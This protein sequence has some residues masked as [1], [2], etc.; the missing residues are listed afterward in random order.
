MRGP[1]ERGARVVAARLIFRGALVAACLL[2]GGGCALA[3]AS[4][5]ARPEFAAGTVSPRAARNA[6]IFDRV[7]RLVAERHHDPS[8]GGL[9]WTSAG[10][11]HG[12]AAVTASDDE[13]LYRELNGMLEPLKDSHTRAVS[14]VRAAERRASTRARTGF[15]MERLEGRWV[16]NEVLPGSPAEVAG[17]RPG[18]IVVAREGKPLGE[19]IDFRPTAG[20]AA[21]WEFLDEQDRPVRVA[22]VARELATAPRREER[23][24][25]G[26]I[27]LLRFD[28]FNGPA[29]RW[30]S[31]RL[32]AR[33]DAPA[34]VIDLRWNSGGETFSLGIIIGEFFRQ[35]VDC[36]VFVTRAGTSAV[37]SSWQ[38]GSAR[39]AGRVVVLIDRGTASA[40]EIF[41]AVLQDH[42]R[43]TV[44]GR[45]TA[46]A[47]LA[48]W[49]YELPDGGQ[50]Q[51]SREDYLAPKGRRLEGMGVGPDLAVPRTLADLRAGRD[52][53]I[54]AAIL[55]LAGSPWPGFR[56]SD[57][58]PP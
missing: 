55:L 40:A 26:G 53:D 12:P 49:F 52:P 41:A 21:A 28:E 33:A 30:L 25:A 10:R 50:L 57:S 2:A 42:G 22:P 38:W 19:E 13:A 16:V 23:M 44:L 8:L 14:P 6:E 1:A 9:D 39:Y 4:R 37:K 3:P 15:A 48:S 18:W 7:W 47:V 17:I 31:E 54:E 27:P 32:K 11:R 46:G 51:L 34:V 5:F 35:A 43:A 36:G 56:K 20:E 24:L 58:S 45:P 29:R